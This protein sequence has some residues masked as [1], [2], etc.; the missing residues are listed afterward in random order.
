MPRHTWEVFCHA[1]SAFA[2]V[3]DGHTILL[4]YDA[5]FDLVRATDVFGD[6]PPVASCLATAAA[7]G[8]GWPERIRCGRAL[9]PAV[10]EAVREHR[11]TVYADTPS[12]AFRRLVEH[13]EASLERRQ[14]EGGIHAPHAHA[15]AWREAIAELQQE[16]PWEVLG[17]EVHFHFAGGPEELEEAL[18]MVLGQAGEQQGLVVY[19]SLQ[20]YALFV[21]GSTLGVMEGLPY[22]VWCAHLD[23]MADFDPATQ[24][25]FRRK[26]LVFGDQALLLFQLDGGEAHRLHPA[27]EE[28]LLVALQATLGMWR[29]HGGRLVGTTTTERIDGLG[30]SVE[31][32]AEPAP[33]PPDPTDRMTVGLG[34]QGH[35]YH[36]LLDRPHQ[37]M[38]RPEQEDAPPALLFKMAKRDA[39]RLVRELQDIEAVQF[40]A[41]PDER[42]ALFLHFPPLGLELLTVLDLP[43]DLLAPLV[44]ATEIEIA[45][46]AGGAKRTTLRRR[47]FLWLECVPVDHGDGE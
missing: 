22:T 38:V 8:G 10:K 47:D 32:T 23:P 44:S 11:V 15:D 31:V 27:D 2:G 40:V 3:P 45:V 35:T 13:L 14:A 46:A 5:Q 16:R 33:E 19:P 20:D 24:D 26:G 25:E 12:P 28:A 29:R 1:P 41:L 17:E 34:A 42:M 9:V 7:H 4:V 43:D 18:A 36:A 39:T 6:E 21:G 37:V 30:G